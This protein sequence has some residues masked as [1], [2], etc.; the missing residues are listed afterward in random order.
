VCFGGR[1]QAVNEAAAT[2]GLSEL[3]LYQFIEGCMLH[4]EEDE[5]GRALVCISSLLKP[6]QQFKEGEQST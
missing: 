2:A 3:T 1:D 4:F 6:A 5:S